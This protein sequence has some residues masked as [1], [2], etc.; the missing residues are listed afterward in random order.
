[1]SVDKVARFLEERGITSPIIEMP[2][3]T[4]TVA[5]AAQALG[6]EEARIAKS[7]ALAQK[8]RNIVLV[9]CGTARLSNKKYKEVFSCKA[10]MLS[11]G[12]TLAITG[13]PVGGVCPFALPDG[14]EVYLDESLKQFDFVFPAAGTPHSAVKMTPAELKEV[15]GGLWVDVCEEMAPVGI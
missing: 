9:T 6:V 8:D 3:S 14:V 10:S 15:T 11:F 12:D 13:H 5:L 1:M 2:Q 7:L 4:A